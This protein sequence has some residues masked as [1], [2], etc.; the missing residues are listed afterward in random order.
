MRA[1]HERA[2]RDAVFDIR[3]P[4]GCA[5]RTSALRKAAEGLPTVQAPELAALDL[6]AR[7]GL[8]GM[9]PQSLTPAVDYRPDTPGGSS[10]P[11]I[12]RDAEAQDADRGTRCPI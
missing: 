3:H 7:N 4:R 5:A 9:G 6:R 12:L 10:E 2:G 11:E 1:E 8:V